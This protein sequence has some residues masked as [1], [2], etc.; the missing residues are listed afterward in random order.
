MN[1][2]MS[3]PRSSG[4]CS[5]CVVMWT[6]FRP[7]QSHDPVMAVCL[8]IATSCPCLDPLQRTPVLHQLWS[9]F[10]PL[11]FTLVQSGLSLVP[12]PGLL[13]ASQALPSCSTQGLFLP[14]RSGACSWILLCQCSQSYFHMSGF[15]VKEDPGWSR[16]EALEGMWEELWL[17]QSER[18]PR[19]VLYW[20]VLWCQG[21]VAGAVGSGSAGSQ[22]GRMEWE[23]RHVGGV[24][25]ETEQ[26]VPYLIKAWGWEG[27]GREWFGSGWVLT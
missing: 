26:A 8:P 10:I 17:Q 22:K 2:L 11:S 27:P 20:W 18:R 13:H 23:E 1:G 25:E 24:Q 15:F 6:E 3:S 19:P 14:K 21:W 9:S 16:M 12:H 5:V 4:H 7:T